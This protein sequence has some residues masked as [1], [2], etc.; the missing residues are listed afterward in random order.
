M[1]RDELKAMTVR[2][3]KREVALMKEIKVD[4]DAGYGEWTGQM[5]R[6]FNQMQQELWDRGEVA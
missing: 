6:D 2:Q 1:K 5:T 4:T 3:L